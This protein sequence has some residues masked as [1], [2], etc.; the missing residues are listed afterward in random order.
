MPNTFKQEQ[1]LRTTRIDYDASNNP[2]YI[3]RAFKASV[4]SSN[5]SWQIQK[6][7][8]VSGNCTNVERADGNDLFDNIWDNRATT[9]T[10]S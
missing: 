4:A 8:W 5:A 10:Y 9:V 3:G 1:K 6:L 2:I 7:T